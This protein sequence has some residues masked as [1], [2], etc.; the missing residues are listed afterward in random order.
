MLKLNERYEVDRKVLKCDY[1]RY[2]QSENSTMN[3][4]TSQIYITIP[5]EDSLISLLK[6]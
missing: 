1:M 2:S 6:S 3:T 4:A 5:R